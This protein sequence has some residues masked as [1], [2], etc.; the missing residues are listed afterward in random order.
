VISDLSNRFGFN[1]KNVNPTTIKLRHSSLL[2][3]IYYQM[4]T[5]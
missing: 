5:D 2:P 1:A 3:G 4:D